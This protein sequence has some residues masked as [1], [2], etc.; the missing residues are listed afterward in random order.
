VVLAAGVPAA[1]ALGPERRGPAVA[2]LVN[3]FSPTALA[4][5]G[6]T[7]LTGLFAA[8]LHVGR[9]AALWE[10]GYGQTLLVK[11]A[12]L[13][14]VA[15]TG[16]YNW[17]RVRPALGDD[18]GTARVRRSAAAELAVGAVVLLVT[19]VLVATP[20]PADDQ[21]ARVRAARGR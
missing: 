2:A 18:T 8:W 6:V 17:R 13:S 4:F 16:A 19:A 7:A 20:T 10:T 15:G 3:A 9:P 11:L 12:V 14:L 1:L 5:A 21:P